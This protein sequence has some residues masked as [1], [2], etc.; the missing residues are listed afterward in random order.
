ME[1]LNTPFE[2]KKKTVMQIIQDDHGKLERMET[3]LDEVSEDVHA[4]KEQLKVWKSMIWVLGGVATV[5]GWVI[6]QIINAFK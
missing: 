3:K 4:I 2:H 5:L 1:D 6:S